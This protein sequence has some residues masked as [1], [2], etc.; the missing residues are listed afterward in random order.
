MANYQ[1]ARANHVLNCMP[2]ALP[3]HIG[4][5]VCECQP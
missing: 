5:D 2:S 4:D 3:R 1:E